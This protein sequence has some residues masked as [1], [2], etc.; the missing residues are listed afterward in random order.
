MN[1]QLLKKGLSELCITADDRQYTGLKRFSE[2]LERWN[3]RMNLVKASGDAL[4]IRHLLDSLTGLELIRELEPRSLID[5]GSGGGFPGVV[6]ALFLPGTAV[7]L[8]DRS[9]KR[10]SFLKNVVALLELENC[11]VVEKEIAD[12]ADSYDLVCSRAFKPLPEAF[13]PLAARLKP[14][15]TL[16]F[17]KGKKSKVFEEMALVDYEKAGFGYELVPVTVPFLEEERHLLLFRDTSR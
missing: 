9:A 14:G 2:E 12:E 6:L 8:L 10:V 5:V 13:L 17:Y 7:T 1:F 4:I 11:C 3:R 16:L 15:G